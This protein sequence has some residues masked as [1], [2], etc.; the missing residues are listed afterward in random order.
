MRLA[1]GLPDTISNIR[2]AGLSAALSAA[3]AR[4]CPTQC[5]LLTPHPRHGTGVVSLWLALGWKGQ[6]QAVR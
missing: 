5:S 3:A 2:A 4:R 1:E 6:G